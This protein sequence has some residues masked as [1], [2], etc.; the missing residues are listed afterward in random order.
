MIYDSL[1]N[2]KVWFNEVISKLDKRAV[3]FRKIIQYLDTL[4]DPII[5]LETGC[6]RKIDSFSGDGQ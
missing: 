1:M 4:P 6:L 2:F 3:S 5:I